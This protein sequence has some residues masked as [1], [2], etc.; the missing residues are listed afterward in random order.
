LPKSQAPSSA[1]PVCGS[2]SYE[3]EVVTLRDGTLSEGWFRCA[4]CKRYTVNS[5]P[6]T[7]LIPTYTKRRR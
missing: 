2:T 4:Q 3:P 7:P 1:C 6:A 5:A